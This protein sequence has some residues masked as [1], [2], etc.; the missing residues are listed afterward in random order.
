MIVELILYIISA[1]LASFAL[2][3]AAAKWAHFEIEYDFH[4]PLLCGIFWPIAGPVAV[5]YI[6]ARVAIDLCKEG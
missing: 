6:A 2:Y 3:V 1:A 4:W 5:A